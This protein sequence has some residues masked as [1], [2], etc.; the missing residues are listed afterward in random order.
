MKLQ[1]G[2][3][4][5]LNSLI[6]LPLKKEQGWPQRLRSVTGGKKNKA[7]RTCWN[8]KKGKRNLN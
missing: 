7:L 3:A 6:K 4:I 2:E 1:P 8:L 5:Y